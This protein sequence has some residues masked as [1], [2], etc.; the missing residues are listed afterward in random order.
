MELPTSHRLPLSWLAEAAS[1]PIQYRAYSEIVPPAARDTAQLDALRV[2]VLDY[3][4][5]QA[6][7]RRQRDSGLWGGAF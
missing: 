7:A 4:P 1:I 5:A 3:K 6:I 2:A